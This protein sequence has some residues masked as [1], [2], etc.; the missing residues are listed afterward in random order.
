[1]TLTEHFENV[2]FETGTVLMAEIILSLF[3][4]EGT[5][6]S[7]KLSKHY[8][9]SLILLLKETRKIL[10]WTFAYNC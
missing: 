4:F 3:L 10:P 9:L 7:S 2:T 1:M 8:T 5:Q 6:V